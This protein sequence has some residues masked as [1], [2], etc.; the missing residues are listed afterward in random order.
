[1]VQK[2]AAGGFGVADKEE[3][4]GL[5][6]D[7]CVGAGDDFGAKGELVGVGGVDGGEA[8]AGAV[9]EA[10]YADGGVAFA[11]V[12][13]DGV[14]AEGAAAFDVGDEADAVEG[15]GG[16]G[17]GRGGGDGGVGCGGGGGGLGGE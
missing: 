11:E 2:S 5:D 13:R 17:G 4:A 8:D 16:G 3:G 15:G 14:E 6:P 12:A 1:M 7:L 10:A 9:C